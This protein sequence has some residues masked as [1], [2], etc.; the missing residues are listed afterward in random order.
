LQFRTIES[1]AF[2]PSSRNQIRLIKFDEK[3][4][5]LS[6]TPGFSSFSWLSPMDI[7]VAPDG[8]LYIVEFGQGFDLR[9][10][11]LSRLR[12]MGVASPI[13]CQVYGTPLSGARPLE[14]GF[15]SWGST[16]R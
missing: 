4:N 11:R 9:G 8:S 3:A 16:T 15:T 12:Y 2:F 14:V 6:V 5:I 10:A 7:E 13:H 1:R